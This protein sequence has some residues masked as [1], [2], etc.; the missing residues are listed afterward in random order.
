MDIGAINKGKGKYKGKSNKG[1]GKKGYKGKHS[2]KGYKGKGYAQQGRGTGYIGYAQVPYNNKGYSTGKGKGQQHG[3]GKGK[4][5]APTQGCYKCG[6]P[7]HIAR[8][9]RTAV[10]NL[11]EVDNQDWQQD[12]T[13]FWYGQQSTFDNNWWTDD[14]T[15]VQAVQHT[16]QLALPAPPHRPNNNDTNCSHQGCQQQHSLPR[17]GSHKQQYQK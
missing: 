2:N 1:K 12:A 14:Q 6:Q 7:G 13:A 4:G 5:K 9:C 17:P 11:Q 3:S 10:Y 8:D 16:Q 15:H